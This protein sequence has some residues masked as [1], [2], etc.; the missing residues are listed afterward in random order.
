[1]AQTDCVQPDAWAGV[2]SAVVR[3]ALDAEP[4]VGVAEWSASP[5]PSASGRTKAQA[6]S[7]RS[8][9]TF[10]SIGDEIHGFYGGTAS[11]RW[12]R[13]AVMVGSPW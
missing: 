10:T 11:L 9:R 6:L 3:G 5:W 4:R 7:P 13:A 2:P 12:P 1:M 8:S